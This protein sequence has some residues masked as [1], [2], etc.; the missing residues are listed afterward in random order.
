MPNRI[1]KALLSRGMFPRD[2]PPAF[3]TKDL[4]KNIVPLS[5]IIRRSKRTKPERYSLPKAKLG[6]RVSH[7]VNPIPYFLLVTAISNNWKTIRTHLKKSKIAA[8]SPSFFGSIRA[9]KEIDFAK[10]RERKI[11]DGSGHAFVLSTDYA[12]FFPTIYTHSIPW[13]LHT[14]DVAK[15]RPKD[16]GLIGNLLDLHIMQLQEGQTAGIPIG[17]DASYILAEI[18]ATAIDREYVKYLGTRPFGLRYVDDF[19]M[20]FSSRAEAERGLSCLAQAASEYQI[21]LNPQK[22]NI[23][24]LE[25][26][27]SDAWVFALAAFSISDQ[28]WAQRNSLAKLTDLCIS[29]YKKHDDGA[30]G[31]YAI[32]KISSS[33]IAA[34]HIDFAVACVLRL[35]AISPNAYPDAVSFLVSYRHAGYD[36]SLEPVKRFVENVIARCVSLGYDLEVCW[37]LWLSI[38]LGIKL[39]SGVRDELERSQSSI[40][41]ILSKLLADRDLLQGRYRPAL[42]VTAPRAESFDREKWLLYYEGSRRGWFGWNDAA[43]RSSSLSVLHSHNIQFLD[44]SAQTPRILKRRDDSGPVSPEE[45]ASS[46]LGRLRE[47]FTSHPI[48]TGY[49]MRQRTSDD[50]EDA[51]E[52]GDET[53]EDFLER[54]DRRD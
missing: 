21:E 5:G 10:I 42:A 34:Q 13:A 50:E 46:T 30:I 48:E 19:T 16:F 37:V 33:V 28:E 41:V 12:R 2:L 47:L 52:D 15:A 31:K 27:G 40:V 53:L 32:K 36:V 9:L 29:L 26:E 8:Y 38:E 43:L 44:P 45:V 7:V 39:S 51:D 17:P 54:M 6:R 35:C 23:V 24:G 1:A 18:V 25:D 20:F 11:M 14:K 49:G 4:G 22:T 3:V